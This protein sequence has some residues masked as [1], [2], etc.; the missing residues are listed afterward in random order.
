[1]ARL[2][3]TYLRLKSGQVL[4]VGWS[5]ARFEL[6]LYVDLGR[7]WGSDIFKVFPYEGEV[8]EPWSSDHKKW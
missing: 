5:T 3:F 2:T 4:Y 7:L 6:V 1:M 8:V